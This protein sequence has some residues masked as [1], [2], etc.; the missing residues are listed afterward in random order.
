[1][2][3]A[4]TVWKPKKKRKRVING[5]ENKLGKEAAAAMK[6]EVKYEEEDKCPICLDPVQKVRHDGRRGWVCLMPCKHQLCGLCMKNDMAA[7]GIA[8]G[9]WRVATRTPNYRCPYC[10]QGVTSAHHMHGSV[11]HDVVWGYTSSPQKS[12]A[13]R[14]SRTLPH[15]PRRTPPHTPPAPRPSPHSV[16]PVQPP[17]R[18]PWFHASGRYVAAFDEH[19]LTE[20]AG[21][22]ARLAWHMAEVVRA[23]GTHVIVRDPD[24][25]DLIDLTWDAYHTFT[26]HDA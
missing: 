16:Q 7:Q 20:D 22:R 19:G 9:I 12:L 15:T 1:M 5:R 13:V 26:V 4:S 3:R 14:N 17:V 10:R 8:H 23:T 21:T 24:L 18:L 25:F 2:P 11:V 6:K